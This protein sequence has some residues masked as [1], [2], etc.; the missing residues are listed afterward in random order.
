MIHLMMI[1]S[2]LRYDYINISIQSKFVIAVHGGAGSWNRT[3]ISKS[4]EVDIKLGII[5]ALKS[6]YSGLGATHLLQDSCRIK[7]LPQFTSDANFAQRSIP[8]ATA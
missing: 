2:F 6:G 4:R 7:K 1:I 5:D 8:R 3:Q